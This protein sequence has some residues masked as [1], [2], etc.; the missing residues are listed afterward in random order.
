MPPH[1]FVTLFTVIVGFAL[2]GSPV[3]AASMSM[4]ALR[5]ARGGKVEC[6]FGT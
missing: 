6:A 2:A 4:A 5:C 3:R 1:V